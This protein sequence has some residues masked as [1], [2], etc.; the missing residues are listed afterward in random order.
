MGRSFA[1]NLKGALTHADRAFGSSRSTAGGTG[2]CGCLFLLAAFVLVPVVVEFWPI[3]LVVL[4]LAGALWG[5]TLLHRKSNTQMPAISASTAPE[6]QCPAAWYIDPSARHQY[7]FW[8][9]R[10]WTEH[11]ADDGVIANDSLERCGESS[12]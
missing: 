3:L 9:G 12:C 8:D 7:R 1:G 2:S 4:V 10:V 11:V 6:S 5:L